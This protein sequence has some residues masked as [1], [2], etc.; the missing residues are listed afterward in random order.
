MTLA[1]QIT[2]E[3]IGKV[4][5]FFPGEVSTDRITAIQVYYKQLVFKTFY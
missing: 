5:E 2:L 4:L 1:G 3:K